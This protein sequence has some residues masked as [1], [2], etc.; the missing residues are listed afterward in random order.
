MHFWLKVTVDVEEEEALT[1]EEDVG[2]SQA[3][4]S[5]LSVWGQVW[6]DPRSLLQSPRP[7]EV[8]NCYEGR[9]VSEGKEQAPSG[10]CLTFSHQG[11]PCLLS[12]LQLPTLK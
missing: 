3:S 7:P 11:K 5:L 2:H 1:V 4:C 8:T 12:L 9:A 6:R 10:V